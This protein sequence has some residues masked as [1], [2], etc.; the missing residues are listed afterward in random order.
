MIRVYQTFPVDNLKYL[1]QQMLNWASRFNICCFLDNHEYEARHHSFECLAAAGVASI[2]TPGEDFFLSLDK[3]YKTNHDW[4]FGHFNYDL[5]NI[6][7]KGLT[8]NHIDE[9][10][11]PECVLFVPQVVLQLKKNELTIGVLHDN[12]ASIFKEIQNTQITPEALPKVDIVAK[13]QKDDYIRR[14]KELIEHIKRGNCYEINFCQEFFGNGI[15]NPQATYSQL[16]ILSPNPFSAFYKLHKKYLLCSSPE[17]YIS[18]TGNAIISQ[19]IKGTVERSVDNKADD[20]NRLQLFDSKKERSEN[21]MIVDLVRNDLSKICIEGTV[22]VEELFGIYSFP[23]VHQMIS[24]VSGVLKEGIGIGEIVKATFPMGSMTGAP[25]IKVMEL[26]EKYETSKR[27]IYSGAVG[28][29]SPQ[30][31]FDFNVVIRSI[32]Y[33]QETEYISYHVGSAITFYSNPQQEYDECL[34]K[35]KAMNKVFLGTQSL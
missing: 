34:L 8:S 13:L 12:A 4:I 35:A 23:Y 27:G 7:E 2:F 6:I 22:E 3:F 30:K 19:P 17:R 16:N 33:N 31:D 20:Y 28:Y 1:K 14:V 29:I 10:N 15:I 21:V 9:T 5:K 25:K 26:I 32:V 24:T 11:F 18:K